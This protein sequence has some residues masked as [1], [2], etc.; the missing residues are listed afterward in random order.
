MKSGEEIR[1]L[2]CLHYLF[3]GNP[4]VDCRYLLLKYN[5]LFPVSTAGVPENTYD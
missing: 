1:Y 2:L 4:A 3:S 5:F